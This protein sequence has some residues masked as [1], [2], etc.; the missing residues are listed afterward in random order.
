M[1]K[2]KFAI[3]K[4]CGWESRKKKIEIKKKKKSFV[5]N[6]GDEKILVDFEGNGEIVAVSKKVAKRAMILLI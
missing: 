4:K 2:K 3:I 1:Q 5:A 6:K